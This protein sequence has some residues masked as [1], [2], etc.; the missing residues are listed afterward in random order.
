M[1]FRW[2]SYTLADS[3]TAASSVDRRAH[4]GRVDYCCATLREKAEY[5][6]ELHPD[7]FDCPDNVIYANLETNTVGLIIHDGGS[8]FYSI[9]YCPWCGT[10]FPER[11]VPEIEDE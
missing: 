1:V 10:R 7:P 4:N 9:S 6:C 5:R 3:V 8:S 2:R 11:I